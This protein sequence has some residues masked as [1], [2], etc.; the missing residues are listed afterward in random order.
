[1]PYL[2]KTQVVNPGQS[3]PEEGVSPPDRYRVPSRAKAPRRSISV[4]PAGL[5]EARRVGGQDVA[6]DEA[7]SNRFLLRTSSWEVEAT[8]MPISS[9][10]AR[11]LKG[12]AVRKSF[13]ALKPWYCWI[14][15]R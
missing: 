3:N 5:P 1:M 2:L 11:R 13:L 9:R 8:W 10:E 12:V 14:G 6:E 15:K 4:E 7:I